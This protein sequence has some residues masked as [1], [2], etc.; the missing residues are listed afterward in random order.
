MGSLMG[1]VIG[2]V[3]FCNHA[4]LRSV[5]GSVKEFDKSYLIGCVIRKDNG[6]NNSLF[7]SCQMGLSDGAFFMIKHTPLPNGNYPISSPVCPMGVAD[8]L[9]PSMEW[10]FTKI[11]IP[12]QTSIPASPPAQLKDLSSWNFAPN[13]VPCNLFSHVLWSTMSISISFRITW[14]CDLLPNPSFPHPR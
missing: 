4:T 10:R 13:L 2:A 14:Y 1:F 12:V 7:L 5:M 3:I 11:Y 8:R 6:S 9:E